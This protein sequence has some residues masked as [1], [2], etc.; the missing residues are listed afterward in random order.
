MRK[1]E[2]KGEKRRGREEE[3]ERVGRKRGRE[4]KREEGLYCKHIFL[5]GKERS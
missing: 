4:G 1:R 2:G 5:Y 3:G